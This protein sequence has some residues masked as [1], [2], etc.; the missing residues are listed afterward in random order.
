MSK[1]SYQLLLVG[2]IALNATLLWRLGYLSGFW[3][4]VIAVVICG[5]ILLEEEI[6][7]RWPDSN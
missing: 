3:A 4:N 1:V 5:A 2:S 6:L 7:N